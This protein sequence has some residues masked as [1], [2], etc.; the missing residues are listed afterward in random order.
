MEPEGNKSTMTTKHA[1]TLLLVIKKMQ[2]QIRLTA[3]SS[4]T[5]HLKD[6]I[7]EAE[8][9]RA[10]SERFRTW[11]DNQVAYHGEKDRPY[12]AFLQSLLV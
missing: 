8:G 7:D 10:I 4:A 1:Q 2:E 12:A 3:G 5:A 9:G 6:W 11:L